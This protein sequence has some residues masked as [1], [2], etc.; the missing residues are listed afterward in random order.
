MASAD[1][2]IFWG[3]S[4]QVTHRH[5][6]SGRMYLGGLSQSQ[7][8]LRLYQLTGLKTFKHTG[9]IPISLSN[10]CLQFRNC[11]V[12]LSNRA[13]T[14]N[15][16]QWLSS[17]SN[18][19]HRHSQHSIFPSLLGCYGLEVSYIGKLYAFTAYSCLPLFASCFM[20]STTMHPLSS[21]SGLLQ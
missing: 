21:G 7:T 14:M 3:D 9:M 16:F 18:Q 6:G 10:H 11:R 1:V 13:E 20:M 2:D 8:C 17:P 15:M 12:F 5:F 19:T 4:K